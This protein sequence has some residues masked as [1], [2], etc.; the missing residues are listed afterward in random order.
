M[1]KAVTCMREGE[2]TLLWTSAKIKPALFRAT[3]S[4]PR[5]TRCF[6]S[7]PSH[8]LG[9]KVSRSEE[10]RKV[11]YECNFWK[12]ADAVYSKLSKSVHDYRNDSLPKL[13]RFFAARRVCIA[14]TMPD[15]RCPSVCLSVSL[16]VCLT[17]AGILSKRLYSHV[18]NFVSPS[19][20]S[21]I[22]LFHTKRDGNTPTG[23]TLIGAWNARGYEKSRF[24]TNISLYLGIDAR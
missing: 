17:H 14:R 13:A 12:C 4:L 6:A 23:T 16:S 21:A 20:S 1:E 19:G 18:L 24:W 15:A 2:R 10:T 9:S 11:E 22:L 7:L 5:K 8:L 3:N